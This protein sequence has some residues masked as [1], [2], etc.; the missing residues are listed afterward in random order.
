MTEV[1]RFN[2]ERALRGDEGPTGTRLLVL[3][4]LATYMNA[5]GTNA[6]ASQA[7]LARAT[8]QAA[9]TVRQH[10][11]A[12]VEDG[13]LERTRRGHRRGDGVNV[14][15]S[16][17][18]SLPAR[19]RQLRQPEEHPEA[20]VSTGTATPLE[21]VLYR[22]EDASLPARDS[23]STGAGVPPTKGFTDNNQDSVCVAACS[24]L[25]VPKSMDTHAQADEL[26]VEIEAIL[27]SHG[28]HALREV[29]DTIPTASVPFAGRL[30]KLIKSQLPDK[31]KGFAAIQSALNHGPL[32]S[33]E[34]T[35]RPAFTNPYDFDDDGNLIKV[36]A[37]P[38]YPEL[39]P[40]VDR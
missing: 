16:Y 11:A 18:A 12:A 6:S 26:K 8:G 21:E 17:D 38:D 39:P 15:S 7:T 30:I 24:K 20:Q 28:E 27:A 2:W 33:R 10:L 1:G 36:G 31:P 3:L 9:R 13:W 22:Q 19:V 32:F 34:S 29:L 40:A 4:T 37:P 25:N 23:T 35:P 14:T 5:D